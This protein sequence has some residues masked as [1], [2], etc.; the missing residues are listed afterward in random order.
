[1]TTK[2]SAI[3]QTI[4]CQQVDT[5]HLRRGST[6]E[7]YLF[8]RYHIAVAKFTSRLARPSEEYFMAAIPLDNLDS[9]VLPEVV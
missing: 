1:M 3:Q 7:S 6:I 8:V 9:H 4:S 2:H 5:Y